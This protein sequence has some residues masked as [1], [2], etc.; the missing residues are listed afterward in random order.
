MKKPVVVYL[1]GP[2]A[3][4]KTDLATK[5][6]KRLPVSLISVD[7]ALVYRGM[8]IGTAKPGKATS[9]RYP[10]ALTD[11]C[12]PTEAYSVAKFV[13]DCNREI[14]KVHA[15]GRIPVCVGGTMMYYQALTFGLSKLPEADKETRDEIAWQA[16]QLGWQ[17]LHDQLAKVDPVAAKRIHP[18]DPQRLQRAL[19]V[20]MLTGQTLTHHLEHRSQDGLQARAE[21][22]AFAVSPPDRAELHQRI[23]QRFDAMLAA[24]FADEVKSLMQVEGLDAD[25]P[26]M[27]AVGYRQMWSH[28][29][30]EI[31][32]DTMRAKAIAA[33]RQLAKRQLT[34]LRNH[35]LPVTWLDAGDDGAVV[36]MVKVLC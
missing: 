34:W 10:H 9:R 15:S 3:S 31:D 35:R 4:G 12:E 6:M 1:F 36:E 11:L 33:T 8:D 19:E 16:S 29:A 5:L 20:Y 24:G 32:L 17:A 13:S 7:S 21:I 28:L 14:D 2:T 26:A 23:E 18:N 25:C 27:R 22:K 30:G